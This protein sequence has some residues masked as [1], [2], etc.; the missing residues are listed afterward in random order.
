[1][2]YNEPWTTGIVSTLVA[3][4]TILMLA[5]KGLLMP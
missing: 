3:G 2:A 4:E 1:M 5:G